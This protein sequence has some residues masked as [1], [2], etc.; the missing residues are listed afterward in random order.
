MYFGSSDHNFY[1]LD[2]ATGALRW[3]FATGGRVTSSPAVAAGRV[4][5]GSYDSNFYALD[6]ASGALRWKFATRGERRFSA[7]ASAR[8]ASRPPR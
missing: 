5:I 2:E 7:P 3:K 1:A 6:A 4:Y 8:R